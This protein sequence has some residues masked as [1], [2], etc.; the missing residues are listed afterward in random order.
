MPRGS[1]TSPP[2]IEQALLHDDPLHALASV[3][4]AAISMAACEHNTLAAARN[5]GAVIADAI[6]PYYASLAL[7][8]RRAQ[9]AGRIRA[10]LVPDDMPR[11]MSTLFSLLWTMDPTSDGWRRYLSLILDGLSP[12]AATPLPEPVPLRQSSQPPNWPI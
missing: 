4:D 1:G 3:I 11:L 5:A 12:A 8:T 10:D 6:G 9:E 7:L 2:A